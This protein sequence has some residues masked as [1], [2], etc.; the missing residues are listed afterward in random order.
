V[1]AGPTATGR[2]GDFDGLSSSA[3][4]PRTQVFTRADNVSVTCAERRGGAYPYVGNQGVPLYPQGDSTMA[5][6]AQADLTA[7]NLPLTFAE[8]AGGFFRAPHVQ[9]AQLKICS[10]G[11]ATGNT[12]RGEYGI[13]LDDWGLSGPEERKECP[14]E[15][16]PTLFPCDNPGYYRLTA[17]TYFSHLLNPYSGAAQNL[18]LW[19]SSIGG[20]GPTIAPPTVERSF[21]MSFRGSESTEGPFRDRLS[22]S[23]GDTVWETTAYEYP[24]IFGFSP[25]MQPRSIC[26]LGHPC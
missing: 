6:R 8:G 7:F 26:W 17:G 5:C 23:H 24:K 9:R 19:V 22:R 12:C 15:G 16:G 2:Y 13:L 4:G 25:Y 21:R 11:R 1:A 10:A 14:V 20:G 3:G 18:V